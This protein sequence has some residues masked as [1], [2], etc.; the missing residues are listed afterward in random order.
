MRFLL[1]LYGYTILIGAPIVTYCV[2]RRWAVLRRRQVVALCGAGGAAGAVF[3][4]ASL[5][6]VDLTTFASIRPWALRFISEYALVGLG[7]GLVAEITPE[8]IR[9]LLVVFA[10]I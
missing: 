10:A 3:L 9:H 1:E 5:L 6:L 4:L 7:L 2:A 8:S